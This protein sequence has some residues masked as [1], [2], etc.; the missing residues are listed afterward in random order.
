LKKL[1]NQYSFLDLSDY[2]RPISNIIAGG[3]KNSWVTAIHLTLLFGIAG[4]MAC[5]AI[6]EHHFVV[7]LMLL[8]VKSILDGADGSLA[9]LKD[10]PSY[11]GRYMDSVFDFILNFLFLG[12]VWYI[13]NL[14]WLWWIGAFIAIQ[15][16]GTLYNYYYVILRNRISGGDNTSRVFEY[17]APTALPGESQQWVNFFYNIYLGCYGVF[18]RIIHLLDPKAYQDQTIKP[19]LM[20]FVSIY[21][22]G[23][24]L[25]LLGIALIWLPIDWIL[26][27]F[28]FYTLFMPIMIL[29]RRVHI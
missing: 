3:L 10:K 8:I 21:G 2:G 25:L 6:L 28:V 22:L 15:L 24:Q 19:W 13:G 14:S 9:R 4:L 1:G 16:Q 29:L 5:N 26:P 7:A 20:A 27:G 12:C 11:V 23:F 17:K 18:D